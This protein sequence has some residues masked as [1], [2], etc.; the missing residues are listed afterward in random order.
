MLYSDFQKL[1]MFVMVGLVFILIEFLVGQS[2]CQNSNIQRSQTRKLVRENP[3]NKKNLMETLEY[4]SI[5][6]DPNNW[7]Q[8]S[9]IYMHNFYI[10]LNMH[11]YLYTY[12]SLM[13]CRHSR[14]SQH[15]MEPKGSLLCSQEPSTGPYPEP[16]QSNPHH[17][18]LSIQDPF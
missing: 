15:F 8:E 1:L 3:H 12:H 2:C 5:I 16:D 7:L 9:V 4:T 6:E 18:I 11:F 17:P 14:T 10:N 13:E